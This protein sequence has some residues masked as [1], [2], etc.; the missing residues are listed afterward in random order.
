MGWQWDGYCPIWGGIGT[1][2][3]GGV[4]ERLKLF[5]TSPWVWLRGAWLQRVLGVPC[6]RKGLAPQIIPQHSLDW[7]NEFKDLTS[8]YLGQRA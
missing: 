8:C 3:L 7:G 5:T 6:K 1:N 2:S 4:Y